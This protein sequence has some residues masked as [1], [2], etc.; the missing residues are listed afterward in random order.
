MEKTE[1]RVNVYA[2]EE[3]REKILARVR[4]NSLLDYWDGGS[5]TNGGVGMHK[6]ITRLKDGRYVIIISSQWQGSR[7]YGYIVPA[8]EALQE[9]LESGNEHLLDNE[10]FGD[11]K[12]LYSASMLDEED[13]GDE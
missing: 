1:Y 5:F 4:Y 12:A 6:G 13:D 8:E 10:K 2:G 9:I 7:D 11:L 3:L